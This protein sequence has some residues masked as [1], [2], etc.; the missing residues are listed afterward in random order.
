MCVNCSR[1]SGRSGCARSGLLVQPLHDDDGDG[2][3]R[4]AARSHRQAEPRD[5]F[6]ALR[7]AQRLLDVVRVVDDLPVRVL[8]GAAAADRRADAPAGLLVVVPRLRVL[9]GRSFSGQRAD[10]S[11]TR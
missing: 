10:T 6:R 11:A 8:T 9:V 3:E 7:L 5:R 4:E 1:S 2:V